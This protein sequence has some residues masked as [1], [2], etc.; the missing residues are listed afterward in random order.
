MTELRAAGGSAPLFRSRA[1]ESEPCSIGNAGRHGAGAF[2]ACSDAAS[3][4]RAEAQPAG[5]EGNGRHRRDQRRAGA[6]YPSCAPHRQPFQGAER[7]LF[8]RLGD[9][10]RP[11][12][13]AARFRRGQGRDDARHDAAAH[14]AAGDPPGSS[15]LTGGAGRASAGRPGG[16]DGRRQGLRA[17][18]FN[19]VTQ[20]RRQP[21]SAFKLF[22]Y[23][24]ALRAG[25][26]PDSIIE[27]TPITINGW[28]PVNSDRVYRGKIT[29]REA[30]ARSSNAATV[31]LSESVGRATSFAPRATLGLRRLCPTNRASRLAAPASACS[32]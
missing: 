12:R 16:G 19:R 9:A 31:R 22:V 23:L 3:G 30:F 21:G 26:T 4:G 7:I 32:S 28:T 10:L 17:S 2:T 6:E 18:T 24:A 11:G 1:G 27:D 5:P 15:R 14:G 25:W 13:A 8:R 20:A 29:L